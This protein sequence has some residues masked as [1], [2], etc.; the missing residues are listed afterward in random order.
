MAG[1]H[2]VIAEVGSL[3]MGRVKEDIKPS[4]SLIREATEFA[5]GARRVPAVDRKTGEEV[6]KAGFQGASLLS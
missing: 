4:E 3:Q 1:A 2:S 5:Q 6:G